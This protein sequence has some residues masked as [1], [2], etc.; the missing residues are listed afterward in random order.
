M[1]SVRPKGPASK[2]SSLSRDLR[3]TPLANAMTPVIE[4]L[5][6]RTLFSTFQVTNGSDEDT[7]G[8][9]IVGSLRAAIVSANAAPGSTI[10]F[11]TLPANT[12][13][14]LS[15]SL[16]TTPVTAATTTIDG[17]TAPGGR[18]IID[19]STFDG[20]SV[21]GGDAS[22]SGLWLKNMGTALLLGGGAN[23]LVDN[24]YIGDVTNS[25]T[26]KNTN[27]IVITDGSNNDTIGGS[28]VSER[29]IISGNSNSS[30][31]GSGITISDPNQKFT[32][33]NLIEGNFI[34]LNPGGTA[35]SPNDAGVVIDD[36][37]ANTIQSNVISG[38]TK[39]ALH[40][41]DSQATGEDYA[42]TITSNIIG[43]D[44]TSQ[45]PIPNGAGIFMNGG[46]ISGAST[47]TMNTI[48]FNLGIGIEV[49][50]I[51]DHIGNN[52]IISN[53]GTGIQIDTTGSLD[54]ITQNIEY[55][56]GAA[57]PS[58][59]LGI[60]LGGDGVTAN[61][62]TS[63][64]TSTGPNGLQ[65]FP[66]IGTI[67]VN[68]TDT[69]K[70]TVPLT[71]QA[72]PTTRYTVEVFGSTAANASS[73][74]HGQGQFY[75]G[76]TTLVT[77]AT[78]AA[79]GSL[80]ISASQ[81]GGYAISA[82]STDAD[83]YNAT[84][85]ADGGSTSEFSL[86]ATAPGTSTPTV[87]IAGGS[88]TV[89][90]SIQFPITLSAASSTPITFTYTFL[91]GS[92]PLSDITGTG[93]TFTVPVGATTATITVPVVGDSTGTNETFT[94]KLSNI[95]SNATFANLQTTES[96]TGTILPSGSTGTT[97]TTVTLSASPTTAAF[98]APV[99]FTA[100]VSGSGGTPTG[101]V[102]F[103]NGTTVI[104]SSTLD[105][106]GTATL[107]STSLPVGTDNCTAV[108]SGDTK[109]STSKSNTVVVTI[110][111]AVQKGS[112]ITLVANPTSGGIGSAITLTATVSGT[113]GTPTGQV[114]FL[115]NG[116]LI[117][118]GTVNG[119]GKAVLVTTTL[120]LGS[121]SLV[122][123]YLGSGAFTASTSNAVIVTITSVGTQA[124]T[125]TLAAAPAS[126]SLGS[127][128]T[129]TATV[130]PTSSTGPVATGTVSFVL[131]G[132]TI[133]TATLNAAGQAV[134]VT[135]TLP[136]GNDSITATY[137]GD[138]N[139]AASTS[140]P[141]VV[142][143]TAPLA[144]TTTT[145]TTSASTVGFGNPVTL[146]A[147]V[148]HSS[149][150]ASLSGTV[151]FLS[152][153]AVIGTAPVGSNGKATLVVSSL[154]AGSNSIQA[155]FG[156]STSY[157]FSTA[158][159]ITVLVTS[160]ATTTLSISTN[161]VIVL[162]DAVTL[163][164]LVASATAGGVTPTGTVSFY[165]HG[166]VLLGT[167]AVGSNG[168]AILTVTSLPLGTNP[169]TAVY[170]GEPA[171]P[172]S[173][174]PAVTLTVLS[175]PNVGAVVTTTSTAA[176]VVGDTITV[177]STVTPNS[178]GPTPTGTVSFYTNGT[179]IGTAPVQ[180]NGTAV[181]TT[182]A[183]VVG[184]NAI[185]AVYSGNSL[186]SE[187]TAPAVTAFVNT[188]GLIPA[189]TNSTIPSSL[190][191]GTL[192][193]GVI[194]MTV[195]NV[196]ASLIREPQSTIHIYAS[197]NGTIDANSVL[198]QQY[199][200][201]IRLKA[202]KTQT[203]RLK[204]KTLPVKLATGNYTLMIR[205]SNPLGTFGYYFTGPT[206]A[207]TAAHISLSESIAPINL[208]AKLISG[209]NNGGAVQMVLTN[210][211]NFTSS[212]KIVIEL[213]AST[214]PG[215]LGT[216]LKTVTLKTVITPGNARTV[217]IPLKKLPLL[218]AG[219]YYFVTQVTDPLGVTNIATSPVAVSIATSF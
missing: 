187:S 103:Y 45:R 10:S 92:A 85:N 147:T 32:Q 143:M 169:L 107:T 196:T 98:G 37:Y 57:S 82:T 56:N 90:N 55:G 197:T 48:E 201:N 208:P 99:V 192:T 73:S 112:S 41:S 152:N 18:V 68:T 30:G 63:G 40:A 219:S 100:I 52:T 58:F 163:D 102:T 26:G 178:S 81:Y 36:A 136:V 87:A 135:T 33:G 11:S 154:T 49:D 130:T 151:T 205:I 180:S 101:T 134:L 185:T 198:V 188:L 194:T 199:F 164:A 160:T 131:N 186:Y 60:D 200:T 193:H 211:G 94:V 158:S 13:I 53:G 209:N 216:V 123:K 215:V 21:T 210:N 91:A 14:V 38:N 204:V 184:T 116:T 121:D 140:T 72:N 113:G 155:N 104:G 176:T 6:A 71:L 12:P 29:N 171:Y 27:G 105:A 3:Q 126:A 174:S 34:G 119:S 106:N 109:F 170:G 159:A 95:S 65:A 217:V 146:T 69:T 62:S 181:L 148:S 78:G 142:T 167:A 42:N 15:A 110:T 77:D 66:V 128:I 76:S 141:V 115:D 35:A 183:L 127:S 22:I 189:I 86:N 74:G 61:T 139:Y 8:N 177:V 149:G 173:T 59:K 175:A 16:A 172:A 218:A 39:Y 166:T 129:L 133:G 117:G 64:T 50:E 195:T 150:S 19:G 80:D 44:A 132:A 93:G 114:Q 83:P 70:L 31:L 67:V 47:I 179:L 79:S 97:G 51:Q 17:T 7:G 145:L 88:A 162:G 20:L 137:P 84:T 214:A 23:E 108:Y 212:G 124:T 153:G 122:A 5:E 165:S 203:Y 138:A 190:I 191:A 25:G 206:V 120:P 125:T 46:A 213:T 96:A 118:T 43:L 1:R 24:N 54:T 28:L 161:T 144:A 182:S 207:V 4:G 168:H 75:I 9:P 157:L 156:G 2:L 111:G 202:H 89:G